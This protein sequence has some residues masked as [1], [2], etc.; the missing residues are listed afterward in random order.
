MK[1]IKKELI[2]FI[3]N[4][5]QT[6]TYAQLLHNRELY[7]ACDNACFFLRSVDGKVTDSRLM[8][9]LSSSQEEADTLIILHGIFASKEA[10]NEELDIIV[11]SPD[12]D[13]FLLLIA[14][15][16]KFKHPLYVDTGSAN[17]RRMIHINTLCQ[18]HKD[19]QDS[20]LGPHAFTGCDVNSAFA[21]NG[22]KKPLTLLLKR[23]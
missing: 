12:T 20:I 11:R 14:F 22:K 19:I 10:E 8:I 21:Q 4:E 5:W 16:H 2:N 13:V 6:D 3:L 7:F 23:P 18:I 17:K 1:K 15:C 9:N